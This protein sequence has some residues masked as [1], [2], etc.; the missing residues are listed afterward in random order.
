MTTVTIGVE[1]LARAVLLRIIPNGYRLAGRSDE[2]FAAFISETQRI[3]L[4]H[5]GGRPSLVAFCGPG[6]DA[7][8]VARAAAEWMAAKFRPNAIQR[9]MRPGVLVISVGPPQ[10]LPEAA[11]LKDLPVEASIWT[12]D[13]NSGHLHW[14]GRPSG[15]PSPGVVSAAARD[16]A[17]GVEA[18]PIGTLDY[19]E[20]SLLQR[21]PRYRYAGPTGI[22]GLI[23]IF[24]A[25][26]Y[27]AAFFYGFGVSPIAAI[28]ELVLAAGILG[29]ALLIFDVWGLRSRLP[30]FSSRSRGVVAASWAGYIATFGALAIVFNLVV[31]RLLPASRGACSVEGCT[32]TAAD[33]KATVTM[34]RTAVL[35]VDLGDAPQASWADMRIES[36][37]PSI[38]EKLAQGSRAGDPP[39]GKFKA[40]GSGS[41][42]ITAVSDAGGYRFEIMVY[43]RSRTA[44]A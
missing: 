33:D 27:G 22:V 5:L 44:G 23:L 41:A 16:L 17:R 18:P 30:G 20:R 2:R 24:V 34:T 39:S 37:D 35:T 7:M 4:Q 36:S 12:V 9:R 25:V 42:R 10:Q 11:E 6:Q 31:P 43:V 38:L 19:A 21:S 13:A 32:V 8:L 14:K 28:G 15:S 3:A 29:G 40:V 1:E 26:R